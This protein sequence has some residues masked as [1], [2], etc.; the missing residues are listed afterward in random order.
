[1]NQTVYYKYSIA[2]IVLMSFS[3]L[4]AKLLKP[5]KNGE[6]KEILIINDK[7][8]LYY[9][10]NQD[11]LEYSVQGPTRLEFIS[12][13]PVLRDKRMS[14]S[15]NYRIILN[16]VD[17]INVKHR[18]KVQN[19]VRS[20]QHPKHRYTFSGNYFINLDAGQHTLRLIDNEEGKY[21]TLIR[22][23][24]KEFERKTKHKKVLTPMIH[25]S[26]LAIESNGKTINYFE[27]N[28]GIPLQI[29]A[30]GISVLRIL[31]RLEFSESMGQEESYRLKV[32][33]G[34]RIIGTYY[35]N[36]E[37]SSTS[38]ILKRLDKVPG[39][40]RSCEI[41]VPKGKHLYNIE[42][43]GKKKSILARFLMY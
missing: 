34:N 41:N 3:F 6:K 11:I 4:D 24:A 42:V 8:R 23:L 43:L 22:L 32:S 12:R 7:R 31:T 28:H 2:I 33:E 29:E 5:S 20:V 27:I 10:L 18:Y 19:S 35:F 15:Y 25:K 17:T 40:W 39:K 26:A 14:H 16:D 36:T 9:P 13:Y 37:R 30:K 21:P 1:M 38:Q